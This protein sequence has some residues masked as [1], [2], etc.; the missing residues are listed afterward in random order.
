MDTTPPRR[1]LASWWWDYLVVVAWLLV[2]FV[3]VGVPTLLQLIDLRWLWSSP[4]L[5]DVASALLTVVPYLLYLVGTEGGSTHATLGKRRAGL[6]VVAPDGTPPTLRQ[7][8]LRNVVKVAPWQ[9]GHMAAFRFATGNSPSAAAIALDA[10]ALVLLVAVAGP[11]LARRRG[12][13][14]VV[15]GTTVQAP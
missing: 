15:A 13:H 10:L 12:L 4:A 9:L 7:V 5:A 1:R 11:P 8:V 3:M 2:V 14:D 6:R